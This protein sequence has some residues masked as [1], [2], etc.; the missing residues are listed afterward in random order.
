MIVDPALGGQALIGASGYL[1]ASP[2]LAAEIAAST[3]SI[4]L[5]AKL[6]VYE[7]HRVREYIV[8]RIFDREVDWFILR[9]DHYDRLPLT[10]EGIYK[11]EV[12]PGLWLDASALVRGDLV[13]V[14][15]VLQQGLASPEHA[16]FVAKLQQAAHPNP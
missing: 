6:G 11:S 7:R 3:V 2:E 8:W 15:Q 1:E 12:F 4:D 5:N 14:H 16:A 10:E 9:H 13:R